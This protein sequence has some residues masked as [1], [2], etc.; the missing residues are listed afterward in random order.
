MLLLF[1]FFLF[2]CFGTKA[3][4][5]VKSSLVSTSK[6]S[7]RGRRKK[8]NHSTHDSQA[9]WRSL[10]TACVDATVVCRI[11]TKPSGRLALKAP[12]ALLCFELFVNFIYKHESYTKAE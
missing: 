5:F 8:Q 11:A 2:C 4:V 3:H 9:V 6:V 10:I 1:F 12:E 7:T